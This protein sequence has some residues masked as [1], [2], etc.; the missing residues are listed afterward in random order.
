MNFELWKDEKRWVTGYLG[1]SFG[2]LLLGIIAG[3]Y[4]TIAGKPELVG[5]MGQLVTTATGVLLSAG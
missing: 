5:V 3:I 2:F 1:V 4:G